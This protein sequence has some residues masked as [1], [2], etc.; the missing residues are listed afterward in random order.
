MCMNLCDSLVDEH[1]KY[2]S[3]L[4]WKKNYGDQANLDKFKEEMLR[5]NH[6]SAV[7][8]HMDF[9][10]CKYYSIRALRDV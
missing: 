2:V 9:E 8:A 6:F 7:L 3:T 10:H 4:V 1:Q 5:F